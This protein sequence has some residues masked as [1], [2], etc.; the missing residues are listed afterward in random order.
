MLLQPAFQPRCLP[1]AELKRP[2]AAVCERSGR[3]ISVLRPVRRSFLIRHTTMNDHILDGVRLV[4]ELQLAS[5]F[6]VVLGELVG[7]WSP[8]RAVV[9]S[10]EPDPESSPLSSPADSELERSS[11]LIFSISTRSES[12]E[13]SDSFGR[14]FGRPSFAGGDR[15]AAGSTQLA[16]ASLR[17]STSSQNISMVFLARFKSDGASSRCCC[18]LYAASAASVSRATAASSR[19]SARLFAR[20]AARSSTRSPFSSV[21]TPSPAPCSDFSWPTSVPRVPRA[22]I[23]AARFRLA[24]W[25]RPAPA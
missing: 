19:L 23:Y 13:P 4:G 10:A 1:L 8:F 2:R 25:R 6:R 21:P 11:S 15:G 18:A 22:T 20:S 3:T 14:T 12:P 17:D 16:A 5:Q 24:R 7:R 9:E